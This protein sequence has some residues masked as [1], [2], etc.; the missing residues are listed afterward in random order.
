MKTLTLLDLENSREII[1]DENILKKCVDQL[2][3][4]I[5]DWPDPIT[6]INEFENEI[7]KFIG[8]E[9]NEKNINSRLSNLSTLELSLNAW[10]IESLSELVDVFSYYPS[11]STLKEIIQDIQKQIENYSIQ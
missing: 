2:L 5:N 4:S 6:N 7:Q 1:P 9:I 3:L 10:K 8:K 11:H